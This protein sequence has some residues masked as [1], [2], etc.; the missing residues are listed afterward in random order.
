MILEVYK[1]LKLSFSY[2]KWYN[3]ITR[4][5]NTTKILYLRFY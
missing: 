1:Q 2:L 4:K 5:D 3:N